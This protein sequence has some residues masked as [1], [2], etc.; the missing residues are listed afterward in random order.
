MFVQLA[1]IK[2]CMFD[3]AFLKILQLG[4][5]NCTFTV[6][7][8]EMKHFI[9]SREERLLKLWRNTVCSTGTMQKDIG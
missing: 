7:L 3:D 2:L 4:I 1:K 5:E 8:T 9:K 6:N